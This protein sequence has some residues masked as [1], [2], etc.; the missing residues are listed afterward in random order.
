MQL[1]SFI[2]IKY[3]LCSL[4]ALAAYC[5]KTCLDCYRHMLMPFLIL[6][7]T[8]L[9]VCDVMQAFV[10]LWQVMLLHLQLALAVP[11]VW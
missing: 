11:V 1:F 6:L 10:V 4:S 7:H 2:I 8:S 3:R 5:L 9:P